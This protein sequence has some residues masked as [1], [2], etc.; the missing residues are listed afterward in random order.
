[1]LGWFDVSHKAHGGWTFVGGLLGRDLVF[2]TSFI[3]FLILSMNYFMG[4]IGC[5]VGH[6]ILDGKILIDAMGVNLICTY[7]LGH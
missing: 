1:M 5:V 4:T 3:G 6:K 7:G 2:V